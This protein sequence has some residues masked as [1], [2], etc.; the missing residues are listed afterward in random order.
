MQVLCNLQ[1]GNTFHPTLLA[2]GHNDNTGT[3]ILY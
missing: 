2:F 1:Y 3:K